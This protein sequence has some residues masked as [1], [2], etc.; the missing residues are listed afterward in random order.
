MKGAEDM[1]NQIQRDELQNQRLQQY[2]QDENMSCHSDTF[3]WWVDTL[4]L[5]PDFHFM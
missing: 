4:N 2:W 5:L 3:R 1:L